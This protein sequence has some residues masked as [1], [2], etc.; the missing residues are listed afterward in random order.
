[1]QILSVFLYLVA[2]T[3]RLL[4]GLVEIAFLLRALMSFID[5]TEESFFSRILFS[6]T[7][8]FIIPVRSLMAHF[9]WG[10]DR[11]FDLSFLVTAILISVLSALLPVI[12][13]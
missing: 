13:L 1:M 10:S 12:S 9:G 8:P 7:E 3:V 4:L 2:A 11:P 5:M 6:L